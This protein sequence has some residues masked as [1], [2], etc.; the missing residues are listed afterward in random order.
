MSI[1]QYYRIIHKHVYKILTAM[2]RKIN[3]LGYYFVF[4]GEELPTFQR[5]VVHSSPRVK[6]HFEDEGP[7]NHQIGLSCKQGW[8]F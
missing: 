8:C 6:L 4:T 1:F 7:L 3:P 2:L 5:N